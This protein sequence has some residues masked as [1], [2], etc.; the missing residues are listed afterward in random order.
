[1]QEYSIPKCIAAM[2]EMLDMTDDDKVLACDVFKDAANREIF[3]SLDVMLRTK[4]LK[5]QSCLT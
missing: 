5:N 4:W 3:L 1:M 2:E